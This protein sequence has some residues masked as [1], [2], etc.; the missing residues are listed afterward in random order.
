MNISSVKESSGRYVDMIKPRKAVYFGA[1]CE[2]QEVLRMAALKRQ[3]GRFNAAMEREPTRAK[4]QRSARS[5]GS[6]ASDEDSEEG[7]PDD[8]ERRIAFEYTKTTD[9]NRHLPTE[10]I[11]GLFHNTNVDAF[12]SYSK[13]N[14]HVWSASSGA[15]LVATSLLDVTGS[16]T[17]NAAAYSKSL[18]LYFVASSDFKIHLF[19]EYFVYVGWFPLNIRLV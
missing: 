17:I 10:V 8:P 11:L 18:R 7:H 15:Q 4:R 5:A 3:I 12:V 14:L 2:K 13:S 9:Y 19:N 16:E 1:S 6:W